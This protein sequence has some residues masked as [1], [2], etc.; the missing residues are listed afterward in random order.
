M[1]QMPLAEYDQMVKALASDR[2]DQTFGMTVLPRRARRCRSV[3]NAHRSKAS[4]ENLSINPVTIANEILRRTISA[5]CFIHLT[6][7]PLGRRVC[8][9]IDP[10]DPTSIMFKDQQ[11]IQKSKRDR[12]NHEQ[13]DR[14]DPLCMIEE[15]CPP[16]LRWR[17]PAPRHILGHRGLAHIDAELEELSMYPRSAPERVGHTHLADQSPNFGG[18]LRSAGSSR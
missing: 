3:A 16:A 4:S 18:H 1:A 10:E 14:G 13:I 11:S 9:Y 17:T 15:E 7:D 2:A 5:T 6:R 12:R 8:G